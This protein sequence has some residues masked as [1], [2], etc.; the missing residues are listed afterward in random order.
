MPRGIGVWDFG[1]VKADVWCMQV[2]TLIGPPATDAALATLRRTERFE[3]AVR[4][5]PQLAP[6]T[7]PARFEPITEV[8]AGGLLTNTFRGQLDAKGNVAVA[9]RPDT[10]TA[11]ACR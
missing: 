8:M 3:A 9:G 2:L 1:L 6:W 5:I 11:G 4:R 7:D 10:A